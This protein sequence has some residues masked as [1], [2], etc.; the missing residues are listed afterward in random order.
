[1]RAIVGLLAVLLCAPAFTDAPAPATPLPARWH[2]RWS[3]PLTIHAPGRAA[4]VLTLTLE[5]RPARGTALTWRI[6][7]APT[8]KPPIVRDYR[9]LLG[10]T[11][12]RYQ[13][14][15]GNGVR[16]G[17]RLL[18]DTLYAP[19]KL[20]TQLLT[21]RYRRVADRLEYEL[22]V[23]ALAPPASAGGVTSCRVLQLQQA[24]LRLPKPPPAPR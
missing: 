19:F 7:F 14:D 22:T 24:T 20:G 21:A 6:T 17:A 4:Q 1:M 23:I 11:A 9:L 10:T 12:G 13:I 8:G 5:I 18:G 2:G 16:L 3:G 15:E